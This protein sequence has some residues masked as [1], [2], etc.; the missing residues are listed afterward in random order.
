M[1]KFNEEQQQT[2]IKDIKADLKR[3]KKDILFGN[4]DMIFKKY[5]KLLKKHEESIIDYVKN[6]LSEDIDA[7]EENIIHHSKCYHSAVFFKEILIE[8][9]DMVEENIDIIEEQWEYFEDNKED[10]ITETIH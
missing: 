4:I 3:F 9:K 6:I 7:S 1:E 2:L 10:E 5:F 8:I